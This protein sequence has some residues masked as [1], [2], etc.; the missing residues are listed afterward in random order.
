M[1][2]VVVKGTGGKMSLHSCCDLRSHDVRSY[3]ES[4]FSDEENRKVGP[5]INS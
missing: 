5:F 2:G 4:R 1:P 3:S